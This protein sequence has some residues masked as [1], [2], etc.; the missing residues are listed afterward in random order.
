MV[1]D[2]YFF[3]TLH[4]CISLDR[5]FMRRFITII[6]LLLGSLMA[7]ERC[8]A[9]YYS[10]GVDPANNRWR[11]MKTKEYRVIYPTQSEEIAQRMMYYL[12]G[13][14]DDIAY[15]YKYP[16]MSI[17]FVVHPENMMSNGL[18]MWLPKRVEFLSTPA[19]NGYSMP[20][21]KQLIAHEY[22]H[23]A[24][25]NNLNRGLIKGLSYILGQ[26]S[27]T[28]G[29]LFM[30]LWMMEGDAVMSETEMSTYGRGLQ[31]S[32]TM[33]YRAYG[34]VTGKYKGFDKWLS[35]SYKDY[36]PDHYHLGYLVCR[37][38]YN[39]YNT[40]IGNDVAELMKRR[41]YMVVSNSWIFK[42]LYGVSQPELFADTFDTLYE[43][44]QSL[45]EVEQT[46]E[47]IAIPEVECHTEYSYP[48]MWGEDRVIAFK[49]DLDNTPSIVSIDISTG[50]E[51]RLARVGTLSSRPAIDSF[52]RLWW[53]EYRRSVLFEQ[54]VF[55]KICYMNIEN[56][57]PKTEYDSRN[58]LYVTPTTRY[59]QAW[60]EYLPDGH[61]QIAVI[62]PRRYKSVIDIEM[63]KEI[64][65]M[66]WD[67]ATESLYVIV[68]DD[69]GMH[70]ARVE[71]D[72]LHPVTRPAYTTLSDLR[73]KD[74]K[75]YFGSIASGRD[76][77]H[78]YDLATE[79]EYRISTS[80]YGSFSPMPVDSTRV[81]ATSYD[82]RGYLPVTQRMSDAEEVEYAPHPPQLLLPESKPW[83]VI[84]L[85]TMRFDTQAELQVKQ[86]TPSKRFSR[87]LHA[88][89]VHSWAPA[90]YDPY[91]ITEES[92]ISFNLGA[93]VMT[94]NILSTL[95]GFVTWGWNHKE[96]SVFRGKLRYYGL[97]ATLWVQGTYGGRQ[98]IYRVAAYDPEKGHV[99]YSPTPKQGKYYSVGAGITL[100]LLFDK[101]HH[102]QQL[103]LSA[104]WNFS[105]GKVANINEIRFNG[106]KISNIV[107]VGY[108]EG[109][110]QL[111]ASIGFQ[112]L[113]KMARR[114]FIP[115]WGIALVGGYVLNPTSKDIGHL[116]VVYGKL[117]TPGF[118]KHNSLS[119]AMSYQ[120]SLG[121]FHSNEVLS[122]LTFKSTLLLPRGFSTYDIVNDHYIASSINYQLPLWYPDG[123]ISGVIYFK[124]LR[125]N[126]GLDYASFRM[127]N[128][129]NEMGEIVRHRKHIGSM[130]LD[131]G[132]DFTIFGMPDAAT[133]SAT[134][135]LYR[136]ASPDKATNGKLYFSAGLGLPF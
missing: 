96:G 26:Q 20:W 14:K 117:Y 62:G 134:F 70:I 73:A 75:L 106:G 52:G 1:D 13:V 32:F 83:G 104:S 114:D 35:G 43:H 108:T 103:T 41:P 116:A 16:Q 2:R 118:G 88:V 76:E 58:S 45:P 90:S 111:S 53:T 84:N 64:H 65:G 97:G 49:K 113:R 29:L 98:Q 10:W 89:N 123:G 99:E 86:R 93:T 127:S 60:V 119:L 105:N 9:Q 82:H 18:V 77:L 5:D 11:Q 46:T 109:V 122:E 87:L 22:R 71:N 51:K 6:L 48:M 38:A 81:I 57:S 31:P 69:D 17:P 68:T 91:D 8:Y 63:G 42:Y 133:I 28:I 112:D 19:V 27:S 44:W 107:N 33:A 7:T 95:E 80:S 24:Q 47:P 39:R 74:G 124:R 131:L 130:G 121:G 129:F 126:V 66:A 110:H 21:I 94:Q 3:V 136:K 78:Y 30:P 67:D 56:G 79:R 25:Y 55:S 85:D 132:V 102:T 40:I 120:T 100:P 135:S 15:G 54:Q 23:A 72:G 34:D 128:T 61:Y 37:H 101:G 125:L 12:S 50:E 115:S 4:E 92:R 36:I 59:G